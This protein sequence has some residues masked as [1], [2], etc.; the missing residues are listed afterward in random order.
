MIAG[1]SLKSPSIEDVRWRLPCPLGCVRPVP[2]GSMF[3]VSEA[4][5]DDISLTQ[6][7]IITNL[8]NFVDDRSLIKH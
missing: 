1:M 6:G 4:L 2:V 5:K 3:I 8:A 7:N